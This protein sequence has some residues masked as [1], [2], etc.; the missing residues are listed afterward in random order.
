[1]AL[2]TAKSRAAIRPRQD[3]HQ[4]RNRTLIELRLNEGLTPN[5]LARRAGVSGNT[6]RAAE[7]GLYVDPR[8]QYAIAHA[9]G[10]LP[11]EV[12]PFERQKEA[13]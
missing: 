1:M 10:R 12:F 6:V 9:L 11:L 7:R 8:S 13:A 3:R 5:D 4:R 2:S